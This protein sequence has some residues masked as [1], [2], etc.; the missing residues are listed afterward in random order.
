MWGLLAV[1]ILAAIVLFFV[2]L[3]AEEEAATGTTEA[4]EQVEWSIVLTDQNGDTV[5]LK[6]DLPLGIPTETWQNDFMIARSTAGSFEW[7]LEAGLPAA[8]IDID[9]TEDC[10]GLNAQLAMWVSTAGDALGEADNY[11]ARAF[12]QYALVTMR[13][14]DCEI[15]E[16][17]L[18][19]L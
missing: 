2:W 15:D 8:V 10:D 16:S 18:Q 3:G 1:V 4:V 11:Q 9:E 5:T 12:A 13:S 17:A 6:G 19:G 7:D 14:R